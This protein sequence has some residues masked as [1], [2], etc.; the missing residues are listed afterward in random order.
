MLVDEGGA[1]P[2]ST[3]SSPARLRQFFAVDE[4]TYTTTFGSAG[5]PVE[6]GSAECGPVHGDLDLSLSL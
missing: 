4:D 6:S 1:A 3:T 5:E 2:P